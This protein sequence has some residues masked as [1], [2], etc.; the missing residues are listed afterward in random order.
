MRPVDSKQAIARRPKFEKAVNALPEAEW[1]NV[2]K[3]LDEDKRD[4]KRLVARIY[5]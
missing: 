2:S 5:A 3:L 4:L 1:N